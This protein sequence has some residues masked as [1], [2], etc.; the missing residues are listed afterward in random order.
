M[1]HYGKIADHASHRLDN[2]VLLRAVGD[3]YGLGLDIT[4]APDK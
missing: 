2:I 3:A 4:V 1:V